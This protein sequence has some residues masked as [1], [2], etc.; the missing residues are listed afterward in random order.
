MRQANS[1]SPP[2]YHHLGT[3]AA[4]PW[5]TTKNESSIRHIDKA[6][7]W[8]TRQDPTLFNTIIVA[9]QIARQRSKATVSGST[10]TS[11]ET[12]LPLGSVNSKMM[13]PTRGLWH[14]ARRHQQ[15]PWCVHFVH[16]RPMFLWSIAIFLLSKAKSHHSLHGWISNRELSESGHSPEGTKCCGPIP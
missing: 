16:V 8:S 9:K 12:C 7:Y 13:P 2:R 4:A 3:T 11:H 10:Q 15:I 6:E 14:R 1:S 5:R